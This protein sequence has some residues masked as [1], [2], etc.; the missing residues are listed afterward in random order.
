MGLGTRVQLVDM[1]EVQ[2]EVR[3]GCRQTF[4]LMAAE[5]EVMLLLVL[6][7]MGWEIMLDQRSAT[8]CLY[9][10]LAA[11]VVEQVMKGTALEEAAAEA[12]EDFHF[13]VLHQ[14]L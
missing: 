9:R 8:R 10:L 6:K 3:T 1:E 4:P 12:E 5:A 14:Y 7:E 2:R 13:I 11:P